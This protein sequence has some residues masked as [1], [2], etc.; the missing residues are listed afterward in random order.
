MPSLIAHGLEGRLPP[1]VRPDVARDYVYVD[2]AA[3]VF[4]L[5]ASHVEQEPGSV[6]NVGT[7]V[8]TTLREVVEAVR[9]ALSTEAEPT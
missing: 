5:A 6:Y 1:L 8:Q 4:L 3:E 9:R 7:G 2:D